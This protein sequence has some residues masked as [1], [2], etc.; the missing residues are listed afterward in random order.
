MHERGFKVIND[1]NHVSCTAFK[2]LHYLQ[3]GCEN[4]SLALFGEGTPSFYEIPF[5]FR[6]KKRFYISMGVSKLCR[7]KGE[8]R[9][10]DYVYN[11]RVNI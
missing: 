7:I 6:G 5:L 9:L 3:K 11:T 8:H 4:I 2:S 1:L 10:V